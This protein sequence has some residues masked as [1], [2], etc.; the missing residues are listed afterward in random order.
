MILVNAMEKE[1]QLPVASYRSLLLLLAP[2]APH[3]AEELWS[4]MGEKQ[5]IFLSKW[6]VWDEKK[7]ITL[8]VPVAVQVNGKV[9]AVI[10]LAPDESEAEALRLAQADANVEQWIAGQT[11][12][13]VVYV[14]GRILNIVI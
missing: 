14:P 6:P 1:S 3:I 9:R 10:A 4:E 7:V 11:L 8:S 2:F 5:S 12:R 13:K